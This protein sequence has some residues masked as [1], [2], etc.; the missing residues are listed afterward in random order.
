LDFASLFNSDLF[1]WVILP[2]LIFFA[3]I[4]DVTLGTIRIMFLS[5]GVK[6]APIIGFFEVLIWLL[7][8][9]QIMQNLT[10]P[11]AYIA[12][13]GGFATGTFI[14]MFLESKLAVGTVL[15]RV[16][17]QKDATELVKSLRA[18]G[19]NLTTIN[20]EGVTGPVKILFSLIRRSAMPE[21]VETIK[22]FNPHAFYS[23]EDVRFV[24]D[25]ANKPTKP[26]WIH[27]YVGAHLFERRG[28]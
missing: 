12:Y 23:I 13:A 5:R 15:I 7:A 4:C 28:K 6:L 27:P 21:F 26:L 25:G 24:N 9:A 1:A 8:M 19:Y 18:H 22:N 17:T 10:H 20:A 11:I 3:R 16:I 14:G 2:L